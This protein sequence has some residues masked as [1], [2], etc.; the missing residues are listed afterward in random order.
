MY[1]WKLTLTNQD[2]VR[3]QSV[4]RQSALLRTK[5]VACMAQQSRDL[6]CI[7]MAQTTFIWIAREANGM[8]LREMKAQGRWSSYI[9][10]LIHLL[11]VYGHQQ[12][13]HDTLEDV[14]R[15]YVHV[16][17]FQSLLLCEGE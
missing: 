15:N 12:W 4:D 16:E 11:L 6:R 9:D 10:S 14:Q 13:H 5:V 8:R 7:A 3:E 1:G 17:A 2:S